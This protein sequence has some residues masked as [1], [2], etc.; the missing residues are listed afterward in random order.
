MMDHQKHGKLQVLE[1]EDC[2]NESQSLVEV[3]EELEMPLDNCYTLLEAVHDSTTLEP[4]YE[5]SAQF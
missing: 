4:T 5:E 1:F 2:L 3:E